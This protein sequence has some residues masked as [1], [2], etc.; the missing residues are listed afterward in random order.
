MI[1]WGWLLYPLIFLTWMAKFIFSWLL[2]SVVLTLYS[3]PQL[4]LDWILWKFTIDVYF[5]LLWFLGT[6]AQLCLL[7]LS[8]LLRVL[9][10]LWH[11]VIFV[12]VV[13]L[14]LLGDSSAVPYSRFRASSVILALP[15]SVGVFHGTYSLS[16]WMTPF[17]HR[18]TYGVGSFS[19]FVSFT[20]RCVSFVHTGFS[21]IIFRSCRF[22]PRGWVTEILFLL[23]Y[24]STGC[25]CFTRS[26]FRI[27]SFR[28]G[29]L[30][31]PAGKLSSAVFHS[32]WDSV[33][34][35]TADQLSLHAYRSDFSPGRQTVIVDNCANTHVWN[36]K[37]HFIRYS[38]FPS[39]ARAVSTIGGQNHFPEGS[40]DVRVSWRD[41]NN[42][43]FWHVL[44]NVIFFPASPV[45]IICAHKLAT[46][47]GSEVD[48][49][50][51]SIKSKYA[52]SVFKWRYK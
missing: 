23:V 6:S 24:I 7:S 8:P 37:S 11:F 48:Q 13:L 26:L 27:L 32:A 5:W 21:S 30:S 40:G 9:S 1:W 16:G 43:V 39:G 12:G 47:W 10:P 4:C 38:S 17:L 45:K 50:G 18:F 15:R 41:D 19:S 44:K 3:V 28:F 2:F 31:C 46:E 42:V 20:D 22:I 35:L 49:E 14:G 25:F 36:N 29:F 34:V 33:S 51:T 52:Y